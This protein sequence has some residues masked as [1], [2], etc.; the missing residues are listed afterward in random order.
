MGALEYQPATHSEATSSIIEVDQLAG[1]AAQVVSERAEFSAELDDPGIQALFQVGTSA[2]GARAK[3]LIV[4]NRETN[5]MH[6][7][8]GDAPGGFEHWLLKFDGVGSGD[9]ELADPEGYGRIEYSYYLLAQAAGI[10]MTDC[11]LFEDRS[12]R[13]HFITKRFDRSKDGK[14]HVLTLSSMAHFDY[15]SAGVYSYEDAFAIA[16]RLRLPASDLAQLYRRMVFN[17][18]ARNQDDHTKNISFAMDH[19]GVWRLTPAYDVTW[20]YNPN[21][22]WTSRHQMTIAGK[23]EGFTTADLESIARAHGIRNPRGIIE[24]TID[25]VASWNTIAQEVAVAPAFRKAI[26]ESHRLSLP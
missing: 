18:I 4:W 24:K 9:K 21:G 13:S 17:V 5:E 14:R 19:Q 15:N 3:A 16:L 25:A 11:A 12:G 1:L 22:A 7:G 8:Q 2:G 20:A 23:R 6:T 10:E 26:G